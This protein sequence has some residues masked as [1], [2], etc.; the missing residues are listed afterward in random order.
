MKKKKTK[1]KKTKTSEKDFVTW[2]KKKIEHYKP[3]LGIELQ[4][5]G[6][7]RGS[8]KVEYLEISFTYPYLDPSISYSQH[9]LENWQKGILKPDS[10]LHELCHIITDPLYDSAFERFINKKTIEDNRERLT[11]TMAAIIRKLDRK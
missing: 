8:P 5:I 2:I 1:P 3:I 6:V 9:A 10:V 7:R 11:D 4:E